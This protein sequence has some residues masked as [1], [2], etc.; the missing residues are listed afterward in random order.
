MKTYLKLFFLI[1]FL[2][3]TQAA[4]SQSQSQSQLKTWVQPAGSSANLTNTISANQVIEILSVALDTAT[5]IDVTVGGNTVTFGNGNL[6]TPV[7]FVVAGPATL[8]IRKTSSGGLGGLVTFRL[9]E[10]Q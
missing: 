4:W 8:T 1:T 9:S 10:K 3:L 5:S 6:T 2:T 7:P